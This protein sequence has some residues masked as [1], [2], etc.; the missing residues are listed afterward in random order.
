[1][2]WIK[3][4]LVLL[5]GLLLCSIL[6]LT[7]AV[8]ILDEADYK[9][10]LSWGAERFMGGQLV[11]E[12][13]I[14]VDISR[15]LLFSAGDIML[16]ASDDSYRLSAGE[17]HANFRLGSYLTT[18]TFWFNSLQLS[19]VNIEVTETSS[20]GYDLTTI[21]I[22]PLVIYEAQI[23]NL[24]FAYQE[25]PPG[26]LHT[27]ALAEL[28][29]GRLGEQQP[30][31]LHATGRFEGQPFE[32][33]GT[34]ASLTQLVEQHQPHPVQLELNSAHINARLQGT[35]ADPLNGR[36]LDLQ[37]QADIPRVT[38]IIEFVHEDIPQL[39]GLKASLTVKGDY[40]APRLEAIDLH[41]QR[42]EEVNLTVTGSVADVLGGTGLNLEVDGKASSPE[43]LSWL[44]F[45]KHDRM[46][47][48]R[49]NGRLQGD[50][51][52]I[53]LHDLDATAET[54][55][56]LKLEIGGS[57]MVHPAGHKLTQDDAGLAVRFSTPTLAA[58]NLV[59]LEGIPELGSASGSLSL[60]LGMD[61]IAIYNAEISI[62]NRKKVRLKL[63]GDA[64]YLPL[65]DAPKLSGL[66]LQA[67]VRAV[68]L[69]RLGELFGYRLPEL[70]QT[71]LTGQLISTK[72][73]L[74]FNDARLE[75]GAAGEPTIRAKGKVITQ[76]QKGSTINAVFDLAVADLVAA[77]WGRQSKNLGQ[78][79]GEVEISDLDGSWG[80]ERFDLAATQSKLY[81]LKLSGRYDDLVNYDKA[82]IN[83]DMTVDNPEKLG[84][85]LG[86]NLTGIGRHHTQGLLTADKGRLRFQ[87]NTTVGSTSSTTD[88][89][90]YLKD[91]KPTLSGSFE[92][93]TLQLA[94]FGVGSEGKHTTAEPAQI[95]STRSHVF[96]RE[97]LNTDFLNIFDLDLTVSI[98]DVKS[99]EL[100]IDS[101]K[102]ELRLRN[103]HLSVTPLR[104]M[105]EGG[106]TDISLDIKAANVPEYRLA[107]TADDVKLGPLMAQIQ[108]DVPIRGYSN[109]HLDL[110]AGGHSPHDLASSLSGSA[111]LGLENARIPNHYLKLLSADVFGSVLSKSVLGAPY[112]NLNCVVMAF[113]IS[114]GEVKNETL[115]ADGPKLYIAGQIDMNL[116]E[117]TLDIVL[118]PT[119][120]RRFFSSTSPVHIKGSMKDPVVEAIPVKAAVQEVGSMV[121]LPGVMIPIYAVRQLWG[122]LDDGDKIGDG[123]AN[124]DELREAAK[125]KVPAQN[126]KTSVDGEL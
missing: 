44:L 97:P 20:G 25:L 15:N 66:N 29:I 39:G 112:S 48:I 123:C 42:G 40:A 68:E 17:L 7:A 91:G 46:R 88:V 59:G 94:D 16:K 98:E 49:I 61:A 6:I 106:N 37:I 74:Q 117:E 119:Q 77:F 30:L 26:T 38:D 10:L 31:S 114:A 85:A 54:S 9:H 18:G 13:P 36:G 102:G 109:I 52:Q 75:V 93:P 71:Q 33:Q 1:M 21:P 19:D 89:S 100:T 35:I 3:H 24:V 72:T 118:I 53:T 14:S 99:D 34:S 125:N 76:L 84:E 107:V 111:S 43:V 11:I 27:F 80:I 124:I 126:N 5:T 120:K 32:L 113:D 92:V 60:A 57:A 103:G 56:G 87:G 79:E 101:I 86:V 8:L 47:V 50:L 104:L 64:G 95:I 69:A 70:G 58:A 78:L 90:G 96:S 122:L 55:D 45:K 23:S 105:F 121:L 28:T 116:G 110:H 81:Q 83:L 108:N 2:K 73:E 67:D 115:L 41:V 51:P 12:G 82:N 63:K 4:L 65:T 22:P 62:G